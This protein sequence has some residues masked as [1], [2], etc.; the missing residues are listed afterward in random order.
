MRSSLVTLILLAAC[1]LQPA[2]KKQAPPP[3]P[4]E[5]A[6]PVEPPPQVADAAVAIEAPAAGSGSAAKVEITAPCMQV[7]A[8]L[9]Q[10]FI[11]LQTDQGA[12][13][14]AEQARGDMTRKMGEACTVQGWT[15]AARACFLAAK[16]ELDI[17]A[18]EKKFPPPRPQN[19][20][21]PPGPPPPND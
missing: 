1:E 15:E 12:K 9:A 8:K 10:L 5:A 7:A 14:N 16:T 2:P 18:C 11:D 17:R 13:A 19:P 3:P 4:A 20:P 21:K 6:K